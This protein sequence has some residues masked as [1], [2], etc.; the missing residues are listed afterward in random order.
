MRATS[1][2]GSI[3]LHKAPV[4]GRKQ[5][6]GLVAIVQ[7][8]MAADPFGGGLFAFVNKRKETLRLLYW[9]RSGFAMWTKRLEKERFRWPHR[10]DG[11]VLQLSTEQLTWL[12]EGL[13]IEA[14]K[15]HRILHYQSV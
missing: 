14:L 3:F 13:D 6:N 12:L 8:A 11:D 2:F 4:D 9:D 1:S 15:P 10:L 5:I 7:S